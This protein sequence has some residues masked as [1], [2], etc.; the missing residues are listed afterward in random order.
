MRP[1]QKPP[2]KPPV[3]PIIDVAHV[4][5]TPAVAPLVVDRVT[6]GDVLRTIANL[7]AQARIV[8]R[9][10]TQIEVAILAFPTV[11]GFAFQSRQH[12]GEP[13]RW[14]V[15]LFERFG[16]TR[17]ADGRMSLAMPLRH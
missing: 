8:L 4:D 9:L 14:F 17:E 15:E 13:D 11:D 5:A 6:L 16:F 10:G 1:K 3:Q 2:H 12:E 7:G